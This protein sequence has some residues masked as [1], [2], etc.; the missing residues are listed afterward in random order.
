[1]T[2]PAVLVVDDDPGSLESMVSCLQT[3]GLEVITARGGREALNVFD[4]VVAQPR[5][6]MPTLASPGLAFIDVCMPDMTGMEVF[7]QIRA[8]GVALECVFV[9]ASYTRELETTAL[10]LGVRR[11]LSKPLSVDVLRE[12]VRA[13]LVR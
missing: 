5:L 9:T 8:R 4:G 2:E 13:F 1:M 6:A 10:A 7:R 3:L 12:A 11:V